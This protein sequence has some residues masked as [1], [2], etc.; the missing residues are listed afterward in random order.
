M[1]YQQIP[2][3]TITPRAQTLSEMSIK[4]FYFYFLG[5]SFKL[6]LGDKTRFPDSSFSAS[7]SS[8]GHSA[9]DA[10]ASSGSSWC[11]PVADGKYYL[12]VD[13]LTLY[14]LDY[15]VTYGDSTSRKWVVTYKLEYTIDLINWKT[16]SKVRKMVPCPSL[17]SILH[18]DTIH[19][20]N[21][22]LNRLKF[23]VN[24][25]QVGAHLKCAC[26][27]YAI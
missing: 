7:I 14:R 4:P 11:A 10:R 6:L 5:G 3:H 25:M 17:P 23:R 15:L 9:S 12:Q 22:F 21:F 26:V 20:K 19:L 2:I 27:F 18:L 8:K 24:K 13:L 1:R 16:V